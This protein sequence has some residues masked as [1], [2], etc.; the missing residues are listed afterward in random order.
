VIQTA[1]PTLVHAF[2]KDRLG[3]HNSVDFR[4]MLYA[5]ERPTDDS[6]IMMDD[7]AVAVAFNSFIGRTCCIHVVIQRPD[8]FCRRIISA[9]F[10]YAF[11]ACGCEAVLGLVDSVNTASLDLVKRLGFEE[12]ARVPNGGGEG[13][14]VMTQMLRANCRWLRLH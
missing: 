10:Q 6:P 14:L 8:L 12:F 7:I 11:L 13:D 4:G 1:D 3:L 9:S 2:F 5:P